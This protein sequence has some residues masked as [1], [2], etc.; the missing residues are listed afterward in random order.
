MFFMLAIGGGSAEI[1]HLTYDTRSE[2]PVKEEQV[3]SSSLQGK[4]MPS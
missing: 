3:K 2:P 1:K 4:C